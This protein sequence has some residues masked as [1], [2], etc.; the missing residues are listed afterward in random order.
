MDPLTPQN[1][2]HALSEPSIQ[3]CVITA[4]S[5]CA[6]CVR[7]CVHDCQESH[8]IKRISLKTPNLQ[9]HWRNDP[10]ICGNTIRVSYVQPY[11]SKRSLLLLCC[12][13]DGS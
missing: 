7:Q 1:Q 6:K 4:P 12:P 8:Y 9:R 3:A 2:V 13:D 10:I 11:H 5:S